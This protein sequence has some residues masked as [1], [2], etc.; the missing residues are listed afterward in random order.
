MKIAILSGSVRDDRHTHSVA[1]HL[2]QRFNQQPNVEATVIDLK[3]EKLPPLTNTLHDD[4]PENVKK[5]GKILD[6]A[7]GIIFT[8]PEYNGSFSSALKNAID[9]YPKGT[10]QRKPVGVA[11][12]SAGA[13]GGIRAAQSMQLQVLAL[14]AY[15][16]YRMFTVPNV[17]DKFSK[18]GTLLDAK[19]EG[20]VDVFI[21]EYLWFAEA[22]VSKK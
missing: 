10:Y 11:S 6:E 13:L 20:S 3:E 12:V 14:M 9:F 4:S 2:A 1:L 15:P 21:E 22:I 7:D 16:I 8:S 18:D 19:F 5:V 17:Q